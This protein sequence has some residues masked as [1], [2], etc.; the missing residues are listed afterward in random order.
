MEM[1][2]SIQASHEKPSSSEDA[3]ESTPD[4]SRRNTII[5]PPT[6][7]EVEQDIEHD[8]EGRVFVN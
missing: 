5:V 7:Q 2:N 1:Y 3:K 6:F 8:E 4:L